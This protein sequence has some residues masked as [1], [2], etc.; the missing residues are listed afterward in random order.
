[1]RR[2]AKNNLVYDVI[3]HNRATAKELYELLSWKA[4]GLFPSPGN[5]LIHPGK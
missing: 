5:G 1:M 4:N 3:T 2:D